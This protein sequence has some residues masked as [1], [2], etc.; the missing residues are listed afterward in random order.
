MLFNVDNGAGAITEVLKLD[1]S[2]NATFAGT[3]GIGTAATTNAIEIDGTDG[4]SYVYLK[5]DVATT[6]ARVGLNGDD[7]IIENKQASGDTIFDTNS[8]ERMRIDA[9]GDVLIGNTV[10]NP[11]SGF[12]TQKG[13]GY[14]TST[15]NLEVASTSGTPMTVGRNETDAGEILVL[16]KEGTVTHVFGSTD[17]YLLSNVGIG[18]T[19]PQSKLQ[20]DGGIQMA[21]DDVDAVAAKAGTMRY[22]TGVEYVEVASI[23]LVT[24]GDFATDSDWTKGTGWTIS[25]GK[26]NGASAGGD[27]TQAISIPI[28][29]TYRVNYTISNYSSGI[30]RIILGGYVAGT[31]KAANGT[32]TDIITVSNASSNSLLYLAGDVSAVTLSIDNVSVMEVTAENASYAD[33]CMQT[34]SSTYEWVNIV[35][36]TY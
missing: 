28:N 19:G 22:R 24:N 35:R 21:D 6:G 36:N 31:N 17:S 2:Q 26:A 3:I 7:L 14:D 30:F 10:V 33:M 15:G 25:G 23:E 16:R 9:S 27:I 18:I 34:G 4:T 12:S 1:S 32:Y 20:V 11:A 5:S 13:F 29:K 8:I